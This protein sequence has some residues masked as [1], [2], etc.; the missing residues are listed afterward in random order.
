MPKCPTLSGSECLMLCDNMRIPFQS[1]SSNRALLYAYSAGPWT[2]TTHHTHTHTHINLLITRHRRNNNSS[3]SHSRGSVVRRVPVSESA[4]AYVHVLS[5]PEVKSDL[6]LFL[7]CFNGRF[8][9]GPGLAGITTSPSW[10]LLL[11]RTT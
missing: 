7:F 11:L 6:N 10:I 5:V 8:P 4:S 1:S 2:H 9:G 3:V